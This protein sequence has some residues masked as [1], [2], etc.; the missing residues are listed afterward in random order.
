MSDRVFA[1]QQ[2]AR[3][4]GCPI[5]ETGLKW[6]SGRS[7]WTCDTSD[8]AAMGSVWPRMH[9][10]TLSSFSTFIPLFASVWQT[11]HYGI[12]LWLVHSGTKLNTIEQWLTWLLREQ[13]SRESLSDTAVSTTLWLNLFYREDSLPLSRRIT[14]GGKKDTYW[15]LVREQISSNLSGTRRAWLVQSQ[16]EFWSSL[17]QHAI[18][19]KRL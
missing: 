11:L 5:K 14:F 17:V 7:V 4:P 3:Q 9:S 10:P 15:L 19:K 2:H 12:P 6:G 8:M 18:K 1:E 13:T 16:E